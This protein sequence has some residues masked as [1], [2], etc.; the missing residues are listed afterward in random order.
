[1]IESGAIRAMSASGTLPPETPT[2]TSAPTRASASDPDSPRGFVVAARRCLC[3]T[4]SVR[5]GEMIPRESQTTMSATPARASSFVTATPA[6]PAPETTTRSD[7]ELAPD[8]L[9]GV[10]QPGQ[11]HDG[12]AVLVVVEDG[13]VEPL[14]QP[15][16]DLEAARRRDVLEVDPAVGRRDPGDGVHQLVDGPG[17]HAHRHG[18]DPGEVLEEHRLAL[19]DRQRGQRADVAQPQHGGAVGDHGDGVA[20]GRVAGGQGRVGG[21]GARDVGHAGGVEQGQVGPVAQRL[22]RVYPQLA[23][24]VGPE[25]R[26]GGVEKR[27]RRMGSHC[28]NTSRGRRAWGSQRAYRRIAGGVATQTRIR[29]GVSRTTHSGTRR[30]GVDHRCHAT[31]TCVASGTCEDARQ[32]ES[33]T[34]GRGPWSLHRIPEGPLR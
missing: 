19:H 31:V 2:K 16:L 14:L 9:G 7:R 3:S 1:M 33:P 23:A 10:D 24:L 29:R 6:A 5:C 22:R 30:P 12:R 27:V 17:L 18:V 8:H 4:R 13:D 21:D 34:R 28:G 25:H 11:H 15:A 20:L 32:G 26:V